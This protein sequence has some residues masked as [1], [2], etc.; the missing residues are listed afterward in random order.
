M[1]MIPTSDIDIYS[2]AQ[3]LAPYQAYAAFRAMGPVV[4]LSAQDIY[5]IPRH[6]DVRK[7]ALDY[8]TF[9]SGGGVAVNAMVNG[10]TGEVKATLVSDP[11]VHGELRKIVGAP[12]LPTALKELEAQ[13]GAAADELIERLIEQGRFD[14]ATDLAQYLPL[15]I[16]SRLVG[17]PE[18]G[19][20]NMLEWAAATFDALGPMNARAGSA[21]PKVMEMVNYIHE[22]AGP[23]KVVPDS[24][25]ARIYGFAASGAISLPQATTLLIDYLGPS[26]DTTIFAT[27]HMLNLLGTNPDQWDLLREDPSLIANAV[28]ECVRVESPIRGFTRLVTEDVA[29]D[30]AQLAAG[31]RV[32]LLFASANRDERRW[33]DP[34]RFDITRDTNGHMGFGAGRHVCAG[35]HLAKLEITALFRALLK[36]V[37]RF[38]VGQPVMALNNVLRGMASLPVTVTALN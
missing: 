3:I 1:A 31:S 38:E 6:N 9:S 27:G 16:V 32:L 30:G 4:H 10:M 23:D 12:L 35:M 7:A 34:E 18:Q 25:A 21:L 28:E 22:H 17:L 15:L 11:P 19:R 36:R 33:D 8:R 5:A 26:L 2:D 20:Q 24:W 37:R 14:G 29:I 13:I